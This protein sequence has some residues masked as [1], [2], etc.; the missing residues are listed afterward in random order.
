MIAACLN[1]R[2]RPRQYLISKLFLGFVICSGAI[3]LFYLLADA[4]TD[5]GPLIQIDDNVE[6]VLNSWATPGTTT[7]MLGIS[8]FGLQILWAVVA[9]V[10]GY[11][12]IR[13]QWNHLVIWFVALLCAQLLT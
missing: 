7:L 1:N 9:A 2:L 4:V 6:S 5:K 8:M 12:A 3:V 11:C 10:A 13:R